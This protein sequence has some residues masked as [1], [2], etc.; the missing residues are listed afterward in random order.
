[1]SLLHEKK[2]QKHLLCMT[3]VIYG[4]TCQK[5]LKLVL[6]LPGSK[7]EITS[8]NHFV[9]F[10]KSLVICVKH[11]FHAVPFVKIYFWIVTLFRYVL[12]R[13]AKV[14][15]PDTSRYFFLY[16]CCPF[17]TNQR[18]VFH[19]D[20]RHITVIKAWLDMSCLNVHVA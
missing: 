7:V 3:L 18:T 2:F 16:H 10:F 13:G 11:T 12:K 1:M 8:L 17:L 20:T 15:K 19:C 4:I 5:D 14:R 9:C 6:P